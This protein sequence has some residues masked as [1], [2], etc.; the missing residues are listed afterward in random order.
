MANGYHTTTWGRIMSDPG[1]LAQGGKVRR[2]GRD[3]IEREYGVKVV[4]RF[5]PHTDAV[6]LGYAFGPRKDEPRGPA[7]K[8]SPLPPN[9][10]ISSGKRTATPTR[11]NDHRADSQGRVG[12]SV[13]RS[14][15]F[16]PRPVLAPTHDRNDSSG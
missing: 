14:P 16:S 10:K 13:S 12:G 6:K 11:G 5:G 2:L 3:E 1:H 8:H 9:T 4:R 7:P 15:R